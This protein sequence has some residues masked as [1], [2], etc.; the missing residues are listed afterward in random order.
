MSENETL[1]SGLKVAVITQSYY[2]KDASSKNNLQNMFKMLQAQTYKNFKVFITGDNYQPENEFMEVCNRYEG[3]I[4]IHNNNHSCRDVK[5][6]P[7]HNYWCYGGVHAA[8]NSYI[9]AKEEGYNIALMLDDDDYW[10]DSYIN[11]VVENFIKYPETAFMITKSQYINGHL[12]KTGIN[13][14]YYNNYIPTGCDSVR[15]ASVH[16][17]NLIGD[18]VLESRENMIDEVK[19]M[20]LSER[21]WKLCAGDAKL[22]DL[23]GLKVRSGEY[24]SLY[25]PTVLVRKTSDSNWDNIM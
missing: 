12:P 22:L 2:R 6:G 4:Y 18:I 3:E 19:Q 14:I 8:Y 1:Y 20:N 15:S 9:K 23:I 7:I 17:I 10:Y 16:N 11:N 25:I 13:S 24:K 5:L 21:K